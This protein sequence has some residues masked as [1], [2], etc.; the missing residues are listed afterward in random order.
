MYDKGYSHMPYNY[1][2]GYIYSPYMNY[3]QSNVA[4]TNQSIYNNGYMED[5]FQNSNIIQSGAGCTQPPTMPPTEPVII[6]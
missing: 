5:V 6:P 1:F 3:L 4:T 2:R